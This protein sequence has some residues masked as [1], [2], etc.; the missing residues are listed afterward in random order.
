MVVVAVAAAAAADD[1]D[2]DVPKTNHQYRQGT[3]GELRRRE[4]M[5]ASSLQRY[6][7]SRASILSRSSPPPLLQLTNPQRDGERVNNLRTRRES[8][9]TTI[10]SSEDQSERV[11][12]RRAREDPARFLLTK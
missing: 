12:S 5:D 10:V 4:K 9:R 11:A 1:D 6:E 2:D 8:M 7:S 3:E